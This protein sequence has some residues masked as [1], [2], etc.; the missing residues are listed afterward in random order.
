MKTRAFYWLLT[1]L[2][3]LLAAELAH[4]GQDGDIQGYYRRI[5]DSAIKK[6]VVGMLSVL[7][8]LDTVELWSFG[9]GIGPTDSASM[10][11][12]ALQAF[13]DSLCD[14]KG[15]SRLDNSILVKIA[16]TTNVLGWVH[17]FQIDPKNQGELL[18]LLDN[19]KPAIRWLGLKKAAS[20]AQLDNSLRDRL[21]VMAEGDRY[22]Q[23]CRRLVQTDKSRPPP[24]G[25]TVNEFVCPL[26]ELACELLNRHGDKLHVDDRTVAQSG[27]QRLVRIY[28]GDERKRR[29]VL[30]AVAVLRPNGAGVAALRE[31]ESK[32]GGNSTVKV[33]MRAIREPSQ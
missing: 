2:V 1:F 17:W 20:L 25:M 6:D 33:L 10:Q 30:D 22:V 7:A 21:R 8:E 18:R 9:A 4:G 13:Y 11:L 15:R 32:D 23:I 26:R 5:D 31:L 3:S 28:D 29:S 19:D 14:D 12:T 27:V 16:P 24:P